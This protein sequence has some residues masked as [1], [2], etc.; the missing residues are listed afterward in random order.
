[1][2]EREL[3]KKWVKGQLKDFTYSEELIDKILDL[4]SEEYKNGLHQGWFDKQMDTIQLQEENKEL[5]EDY[6]KVVHEATEFE[7][8]VYELKDEIKH[9]E[10]KL[11]AVQQQF[12]MAVS[13]GNKKQHIIDELER[14]LEE[15]VND[16]KD[17]EDTMTR[18]MVQEDRNILKMIQ[19]LR[20][21]NE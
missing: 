13:L 8:K 17:V 19:E 3:N 18:G 5:K 2:S 10:A 1:M 12:D 6:N 15:E 11:L 9:L 20:G 4:L 14:H 16:W 21:K 7:S